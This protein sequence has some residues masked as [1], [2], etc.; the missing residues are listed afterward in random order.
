VKDSAQSGSNLMPHIIT[1]V[2]NLC[3][4]G[5]IADAMRGVFGEYQ[6]TIVI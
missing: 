3:T 1:A 6:E 4:V 2:E 5:E